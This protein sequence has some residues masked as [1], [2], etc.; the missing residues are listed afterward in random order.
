LTERAL[1]GGRLR[2]ARERRK[3]SLEKI[4]EE[5]KLSASMIAA[6]EDGSCARWPSGLYSRSYVR[7]YAELVGLDPTE[8]VEE[9]VSLFPDLAV[10][11][12][13]REE[14]N[15]L[16]VAR[17]TG[18]AAV[19]PLRL[20]LDDAPASWWSR[21]LTRL[22]W[23]LHRLAN[24][25]VAPAGRGDREVDAWSPDETEDAPFGSAPNE[26]PFARL[27]VDP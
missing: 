4:A 21:L 5:T 13:E 1:F 25:G 9:F 19:A 7:S 14:R 6:L 12:V 18:R 24:G 17:R 11:D 22:A 8:T 16:T 2:I 20:S 10:L 26:A 23:S 3:L 15:G 27:Q